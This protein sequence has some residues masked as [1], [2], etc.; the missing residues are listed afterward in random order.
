MGMGWDGLGW[1]EI[2]FDMISNRGHWVSK[3]A[4]DRVSWVPT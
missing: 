1:D 3:P 2:T 4:V